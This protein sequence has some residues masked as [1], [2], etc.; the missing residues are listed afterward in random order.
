M[1]RSGHRVRSGVGDRRCS[2]ARFIQVPDAAVGA[3]CRRI[4]DVAP[5]Q[6]AVGACDDGIL[7]ERR[8]LHPHKRFAGRVPC[9]DVEWKSIA[10]SVKERNVGVIRLNKV[11]VGKPVNSRRIQPDKHREAGICLVPSIARRSFAVRG[12]R[13]NRELLAEVRQ[14]DRRVRRV[15]VSRGGIRERSRRLRCILCRNLRVGHRPV[16][17]AYLVVCAPER[18]RPAI[19]PD[20]VRVVPECQRI[21]AFRHFFHP[22]CRF[23]PVCAKRIRLLPVQVHDA[24]VARPVGDSHM[25]PARSEVRRIG[26]DQGRPIVVPASAIQNL[27]GLALFETNSPTAVVPSTL[28]RREERRLPVVVGRIGMKPSRNGERVPVSE[29]LAVR[30]REIPGAG[31][32]VDA[33]ISKHAICRNVLRSGFTSGS[34]REPIAGRVGDFAARLGHVPDAGVRAPD[35]GSVLRV[36]RAAVVGIDATAGAEHGHLHPDDGLAARVPLLDFVRQ[37]VAALVREKQ[38]AAVSFPEVGIT[39]AGY[40]FRKSHRD[41]DIR[42][43]LHAIADGGRID[44][45]RQS[46]RVVARRR[47]RCCERKHQH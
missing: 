29:V 1:R 46:L 45:Y 43:V 21:S 20:V 22:G 44:R 36:R 19:V 6:A 42:D 47:K 4:V 40:A 5:R 31:R 34:S 10:A 41:R 37:R 3:P 14:R 38:V 7:R 8:H 23:H 35:A 16:G 33:A 26:H 30:N 9:V 18:A 28:L 39:E 12:R 15:G 25:D 32:A 24:F 27:V 11:V 13:R 17:K 2:S